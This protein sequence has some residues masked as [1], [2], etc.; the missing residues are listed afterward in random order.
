M[1]EVKFIVIIFIELHSGQK[2]VILKLHSGSKKV[3]FEF[4]SFRL[5]YI[6]HI[7][8]LRTLLLTLLK[9]QFVILISNHCIY[10]TSV[11]MIL[12]S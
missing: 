1:D 7:I 9:E 5:L 10:Y 12:K 6:S 8:H 11:D 2:R 4:H 3:M